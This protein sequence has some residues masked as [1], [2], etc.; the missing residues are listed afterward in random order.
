MKMART[1]SHGK[2]KSILPSSQP[3]SQPVVQLPASASRSA[4]PQ[5]SEAIPDRQLLGRPIAKTIAQ[6]GPRKIGRLAAPRGAQVDLGRTRSRG[7][8]SRLP[9][10]RPL[11]GTPS[12]IAR[13][14]TNLV[15]S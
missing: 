15:T 3:P 5:A 7:R 2:G 11:V 8:S 1:S 10:L 12:P 9:G 13:L 14:S 4:A 6:V